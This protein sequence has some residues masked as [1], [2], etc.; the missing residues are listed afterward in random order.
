MW[1]VLS[2]SDLKGSDRCNPSHITI[3]PSS[4]APIENHL[5]NH[6]DWLW[7]CDGKHFGWRD[8]R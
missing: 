8:R 6:R 1:S 3:H 2:R 5:P 7:G 4:A